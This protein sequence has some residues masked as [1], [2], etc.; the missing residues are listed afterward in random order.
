MLL[1]TVT[2]D[3]RLEKVLKRCL[4]YKHNQIPLIVKNIGT[5]EL[6]ANIHHHPNWTIF[7][8]DVDTF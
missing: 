1:E 3:P 5:E 4:F 2:N 8:G 7:G 6:S